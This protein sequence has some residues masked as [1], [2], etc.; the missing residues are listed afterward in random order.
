[1]ADVPPTRPGACPS[2]ETLDA[3][4]AGSLDAGA[5]DGVARHL[6]T[7]FMCRAVA[8][9]LAKAAGKS[10]DAA[11]IPARDGGAS[12]RPAAT[13]AP[14][15]S[16]NGPSG[17]APSGNAPASRPS[18]TGAPSPTGGDAGNR[19][20]PGLAVPKVVGVVVLVVVAIG[21]YLA[22]KSCG[23]GGGA[24][25]GK[26]GEAVLA[27][28]AGDLAAKSPDLFAGF[29]PVPR[30]ERV[31]AQAMVR[32]GEIE[33]HGPTEVVLGGRPRFAWV[34]SGRVRN[35]DLVLKG[36]DG[37]TAWKKRIEGFAAPFPADEAPLPAGSAWTWEVSGKRSTGTVRGVRTFR[38]ATDDERK[39]YE[40]AVAVVRARP[41]SDRPNLVVAH[42]ALRAGLLEE[43]EAAAAADV[44]AFP[45]DD[46]GRTTL[47]CVRARL[48]IVPD[49]P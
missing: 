40:A 25:A 14:A 38:V 35:Y 12:S 47:A 31:A 41:A 9:G 11:G 26:D 7:C 17:G 8:V 4:V 13:S 29:A 21:L 5:R 39:R 46:A 33:V 10:P 22:L 23:G 3:F 44:R 2:S 30:G 48:G 19:R 1:M 34:Q 16:G 6:A 42:L 32:D 49:G 15:P 24:S 20:G 36:A 45:G 28:V 43:A 27:A 37:K 18:P